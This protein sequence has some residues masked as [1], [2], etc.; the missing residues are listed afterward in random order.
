V[1]A[2]VLV[3]THLA[4]DADAVAL[5]TA[6]A[7]LAIDSGVVNHSIGRASDSDAYDAREEDDHYVLRQVFDTA[8]GAALYLTR[9]A[10]VERGEAGPQI[11]VRRTVRST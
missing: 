5:G 3:V 8:Q 6:L 1:T 2:D 11:V 9:V 4:P 7:Q 10:E